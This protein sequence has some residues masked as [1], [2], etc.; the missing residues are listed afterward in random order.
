MFIAAAT[1]LQVAWHAKGIRRATP[2]VAATGLCIVLMF[3]NAVTGTAAA[4]LL[5]VFLLLRAGDNKSV[6]SHRLGAMAGALAVGV[7]FFVAMPGDGS[8]SLLPHFSYTAAGELLRHGVI[9]IPLAVALAWNVNRSPLVV[10]GSVVFYVI[11]IAIYL[12][13]TRDIVV[14]NASRF[15]YHALLIAWPLLVFPIVRAALW[16]RVE[17]VNTAQPLIS[18]LS[19]GALT[20]IVFALM[21]TPVLAAGAS[22]YDSLV[23]SEA[24]TVSVDD[25]QIYAW[26]RDNTP[27]NTVVISDP[28]GPWL[29]PFFSG[30]TL[31]RTN[32]WLDPDDKVTN[33]VN[34]AFTGDVYAQ[35]IVS[36]IADY[37]ILDADA[38]TWPSISSAP[39]FSTNTITVWRF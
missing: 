24:T 25:V 20:A 15:F 3:S 17:I 7:L 29:I 11:G 28:S 22:S 9:F 37:L 26:F 12:L 35:E 14:E 23:R 38:T 18:R 2:F 1:L 32:Y 13:S 33:L 8:L 5:I 16:L 31:L 21:I 36:G 6:N 27:P 10:V 34:E 4:A 30:R 19:L 39:L